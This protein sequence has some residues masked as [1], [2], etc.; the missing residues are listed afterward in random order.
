MDREQVKNKRKRR[1][2]ESYIELKY[3]VD[4]KHEELINIANRIDD[5][6]GA[7]A[8][9]Y[10]DMPKGGKPV[11]FT[12]TIDY[13]VDKEIILKNS[14]ERAERRKEEIESAIDKL[15]DN[16]L[17]IILKMKYIDD[18]S[19]SKIGGLINCHK[20]TAW[21]KCNDAIRLINL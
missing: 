16:E 20:N 8:I 14:L 9:V 4:R 19:F 21:N 10:D 3:E 18:Y 17:R 12:D 1:K 5:L 11:L 15:E 13:L 2:L 6:A 7:R